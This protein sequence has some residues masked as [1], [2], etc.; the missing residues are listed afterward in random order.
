MICDSIVSTKDVKEIAKF[1]DALNGLVKD[2][3]NG[4]KFIY[5]LDSR[6]DDEVPFPMR[7]RYIIL[8]YIQFYM[9]SIKMYPK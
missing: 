6:N 8:K 9:S 1:V 4:T 3:E 5:M 7:K 2:K